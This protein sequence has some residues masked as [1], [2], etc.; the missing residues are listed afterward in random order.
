MGAHYS[1]QLIRQGGGGGGAGPV[2]ATKAV[3]PDRR[4]TGA[5]G[6]PHGPPRWTAVITH[7]AAAAADSV[8]HDGVRRRL[9]LRNA[10]MRE[11]I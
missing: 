8:T 1:N 9:A 2:H 11:I 6:G 10:A 7:Q 4:T 5:A 3:G